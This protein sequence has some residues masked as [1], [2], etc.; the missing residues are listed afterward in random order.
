V[1]PPDGG[2]EGL[3]E[4]E[5][6]PVETATATPGGVDGDEGGVA[7]PAPPPP[8]LANATSRLPYWL[9]IVSVATAALASDIDGGPGL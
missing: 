6:A 3:G 8:P 5:A 9:K 4:P 2:L 1:L 7:A